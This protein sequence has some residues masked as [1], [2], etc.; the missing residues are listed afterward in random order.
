VWITGPSTSVKTSKVVVVNPTTVTATF[1]AAAGAAVGAYTVVFSDGSFGL[2][3]C[4]KCLTVIAATTFTRMSPSSVQHGKTNV[5]VHLTGTHFVAG[6]TITGPSGTTFTNVV[7]VNS[8]TMTALLTVSATAT[9]G[10]KLPVT[11]ANNATAGYG[12][13][14]AKLLTIT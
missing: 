10:T 1:T 11:V 5:T 3:Q 8:T 9:L 14:T 12:M 2:S 6:A 4:T 7:V 13:A